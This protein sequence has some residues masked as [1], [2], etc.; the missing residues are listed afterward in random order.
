MSTLKKVINNSS[1]TESLTIISE[2]CKLEGNF[3][4]QGTM[5]VYGSLTG[6]IKCETL[7]IGK[8][9]RINANVKADNVSIGG[10]FRGEIVCSGGL[11]IANTGKVRGRISYGSLSI[12]D[13]GQLEGYVAKKLGSE[14]TELLPLKQNDLS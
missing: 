5:I 12:E 10:S 2:S 13:G 3:E 7:E 6:G 1:Q 4:T 11:F 14:N 8:N 9:G